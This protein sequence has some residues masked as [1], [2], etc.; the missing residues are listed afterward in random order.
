MK[1]PYVMKKADG[2]NKTIDGLRTFIKEVYIPEY[3][4]SLNNETYLKEHVDG[5]EKV[6]KVLTKVAKYNDA[7][8]SL[9]VIGVLAVG[10]LAKKRFMKHTKQIKELEDKYEN[11]KEDYD[12]IYHKVEELEAEM[13]EMEERLHAV[14]EK[15][16]KKEE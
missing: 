15:G 4:T 10:F 16:D 12:D 3:N 11:I 14:A 2:S 9:A 13:Y 7:R 1:E 6:A 5:L 8:S